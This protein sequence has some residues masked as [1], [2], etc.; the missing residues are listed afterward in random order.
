MIPPDI[1]GLILDMDGVIWKADSPIGDLPAIFARIQE[2][3]LKFVFATNNGTKTPE[4]YRQRLADFGVDVDPAQVITSALAI[5]HT[6]AQKYPTGTKIFMLGE[7]GIRAA[8]QG[9]GFEI[10]SIQDAPRAQVVVMGIDRGITFD[11]IAEAT[12]A[13]EM[14]TTLEDLE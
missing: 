1:S 4:E 10:V 12:L 6:L 11:K 7:E 5:A 3:S 14:G 2:R 8:L 13:M 9:Q